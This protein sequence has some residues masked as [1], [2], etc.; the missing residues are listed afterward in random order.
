MFS[1]NVGSFM[2]PFRATSLLN[3]LSSGKFSFKK[4]NIQKSDCFF[5]HFCFEMRLFDILAFDS[6][7]FV[8][9]SEDVIGFELRG[10]KML[11]L[12]CV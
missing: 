11:F 7:A 10:H 9:N 4:L 2:K 8:L 1:K 12:F 6:S 5:H 3:T